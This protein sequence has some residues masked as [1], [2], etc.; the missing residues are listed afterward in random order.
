MIDGFGMP[1]LWS[2]LDLHIALQHIQNA[3]LF[4]SM[5]DGENTTGLAT[6][7]TVIVRAVRV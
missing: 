4:V 6:A 1:L 5:E 3:V 2:M 7:A